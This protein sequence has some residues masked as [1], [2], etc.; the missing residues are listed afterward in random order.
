MAVEPRSRKLSAIELSWTRNI[1]IA[2]RSLRNLRDSYGVR[3]VVV[4]GD[5]W[6]VEPSI[7][8]GLRLHV[9]IGGIHNIVERLSREVKR[10]LRSI[11]L[12]LPCRCRKPFKNVE[13]WTNTWRT[14]YN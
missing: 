12:Y 14:Y 8:L 7:K 4:D 2:Y 6:Y 5:S 13:R 10:R 1:L 3:I 11:N 9:E